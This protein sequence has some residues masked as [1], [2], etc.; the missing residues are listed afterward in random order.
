MYRK[1]WRC[2]SIS[3][4]RCKIR[5]LS[6]W[7]RQGDWDKTAL[8]SHHDLYSFDC[9]PLAL[10]GPWD[11]PTC[12]L[13][14]TRN[15]KM[16]VQPRQPW[17]RYHLLV[18]TVGTRETRRQS[19][20]STIRRQIYDKSQKVFFPSGTIDCL[21]A[22]I[23][24]GKLE[25]PVRTS[26]A[27]RNLKGPRHLTDIRS[28]LGLCNAF[29]RLHL[30]FARIADPLNRNFHKNQSKS[31]EDVTYEERNPLTTLKNF[32]YPLIFSAFLAP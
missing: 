2:S 14:Y 1:T 3:D 18:I 21:R 12:N 31:I 7:V 16:A 4:A 27:I 20:T 19:T 26:G 29:C 5:V 15:S 10:N 25:I 22:V 11:A 13:R 9:M 6:N 17:R 30:N 32:L 8:I 23:C 28:L 24:P